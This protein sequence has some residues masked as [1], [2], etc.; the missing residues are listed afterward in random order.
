MSPRTAETQTLLPCPLAE[1][2]LGMAWVEWCHPPR[3]CHRCG[4]T[5]LRSGFKRLTGPDKGQHLCVECGGEGAP[6]RHVK[7]GPADS[8]DRPPPRARP[9]RRKG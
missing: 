8:G 9:V 6:T 4:A 7:R 3:S 5:D 2:P 1:I